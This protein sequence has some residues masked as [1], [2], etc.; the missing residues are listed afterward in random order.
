MAPSLSLAAGLSMA[1]ALG[2]WAARALTPAGAIAAVGVGTATLFGA[3]W[4]GAVAL[5]VFFVGS[6][7]I[8]RLPGPVGRSTEEKGDRRD[9]VQVIANGGAAAVA[10]LAFRGE[11]VLASWMVTASLAAAAADTWATETGIRSRVSPRLLLLGPAVPAGTNGGMTVRGTLGATTGAASVAFTTG[12][13]T[14]DYSLALA[15]TVIGVLGMLADSFLGAT[16]QARFHC[17]TCGTDTERR[18]HRCGAPTIQA[19]GIPWLGNDG[20][21]AAA[22]TLAALGGLVAHRWLA[23]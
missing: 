20:V 18:T 9:A 2:G 1:V 3:G 14:G 19:G 10:A 6:S 11:P 23:T 12:A 8:S 21:N 13:L 15:G 4:P 5:V 7:A 17:G 22:T 16:V